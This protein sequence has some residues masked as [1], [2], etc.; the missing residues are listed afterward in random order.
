MK[1]F[2]RA[3]ADGEFAL[4][5]ELTL[6]QATTAEAVLEQACRLTPWVNAIQV[7]DNPWAWIQMSA[8]SAASILLPAGHDV[9]PI[10]TCRDRN[11]AALKRE[12]TGL[13]SLGAETVILVRGHRVP[14]AH[15]VPAV[16]VF[17]LTGRELI[18][19]GRSMPDPGF[20][21]GSGARVFRAPEGWSGDSLRER[22]AAGAGFVQT[23]ICFNLDILRSW[24]ERFR[25]AGLDESFRVI[26]CLSPLPS[27]RTARWVKENMGDSRVPES[28]IQRLESAADPRREGIEACAET[29]REVSEIA[30]VS[31]I[32]LMTTGDDQSVADAIERSG[33]RD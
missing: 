8:L 28:L 19:L 2:R 23:Q 7:S 33:L 1:R 29:M 14:K 16:T 24:M 27:A 12:L 5:A 18:A 4:T 22:A 30:G 26:V 6:R 25:S 3:L 15:S 11:R 21:I 17:D 10:L 9:I 13:H 32:H 20:L 31:G